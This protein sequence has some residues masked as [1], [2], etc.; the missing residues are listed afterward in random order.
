MAEA[1]LRC[2]DGRE[3]TAMSRRFAAEWQAARARGEGLWWIITRE[4]LPNAAMPLATDFGLRLVFVILFISS[5]SF[6]GL[7]PEPPSPE[8]GAML[9]AG[10]DELERNPLV[11]LVPGVAIVITGYLAAE[12]GRRLEEPAAVRQR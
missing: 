3:K 8:W 5:L 1:V 12:L 2:G 4:V 11:P 10:V 6:L 9:T 7:G